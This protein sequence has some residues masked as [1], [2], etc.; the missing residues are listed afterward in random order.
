MTDFLIKIP[1]PQ[2]LLISAIY[3]TSVIFI[4]R[5]Y[6]KRDY[7][8]N[9]E[10]PEP[11]KIEPFEIS[12]LKFGIKGAVVTSIFNLWKNK[13]LHIS[14]ADKHFAI[15]QKPY[16]SNRLNRLERAIYN[17]AGNGKFYW[18]FFNRQSLNTVEKILIEPNLKLQELKLIPDKK[19]KKYQWKTVI[20]G[21]LFILIPNGIKLYFGIIRN[22]PHTLLIFFLIIYVIAIILFLNPNKEKISTLGAR[23]L[24]TSEKRF[25]WLKFSK[26]GEDLL[27]DNNLL[28]AIALFGVSPFMGLGL[29]SLLDISNSYPPMATNQSSGNGCS[30]CGGCSGGCGGGCGGCGG[31]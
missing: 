21:I 17:F 19:V 2:F 22:K 15:S 8:K 29:G 3:S 18:Q 23:F 20:F 30:G 6:L 12:I 13:A 25:E 24:K 16:S 11:T 1:G 4:A 9:L 7:T 5:L 27:A 28:Y 26:S 31:D 10:I 14:Q